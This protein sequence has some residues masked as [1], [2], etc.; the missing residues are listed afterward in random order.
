MATLAACSAHHPEN[1]TDQSENI[2]KQ[3]GNNRETIYQVSLLQSLTQGYYDGII[4]VSELKE[5]GDIDI[6]STRTAV[7]ISPSGFA[8][9]VVCRIVLFVDKDRGSWEMH[10]ILNGKAR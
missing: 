6:D 2:T 3:T 9:N 10:F 7:M 5:H 8:I 1:N 4:K